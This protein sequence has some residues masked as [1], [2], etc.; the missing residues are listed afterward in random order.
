[1]TFFLIM[2]CNNMKLEDIMYPMTKGIQILDSDSFYGRN[3]K[4]KTNLY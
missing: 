1:M 3:R 4:K 2:Q